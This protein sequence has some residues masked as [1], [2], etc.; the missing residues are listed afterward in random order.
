MADDP[1]RGL[2]M[3]TATGTSARSGQSSARQPVSWHAIDLDGVIARL[4][5]DPVRGL[6]AA[7]A[8]RRLTD[9]GPNALDEPPSRPWWRT[10]LRQ[11]EELVIWILLVAAVI[12]GGMGD[13][14]DAAAIVAI[15]LVNAIIGFLQEERAQKA[16][17]ALQRMAA[18][19]A[20][21]VRDGTRASIPAREVVTGDRIDLEAGDQVPADARLI[22]AFGLSAQESALTGESMP[23]EKSPAETLPAATPLGDRLSLVHAGTVVAAGSGS[24]IVVATGMS[25][26]IG[27]IAGMLE[28]SPPEPTPL[29][30]KLAALG[31]ILVAVCLAVVGMIFLMELARGGGLVELWRT[32]RLGDVLLRAVSLAVAAVPEG[33]PAVVTL[34]LAL[35]LQR[36]VA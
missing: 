22:E 16:L 28:R 17:A 29:Q 4:G 8:A 5:A 7:E 11:F 2:T 24:A 12:A 21:V 10:F 3:N 30:R 9:H 26:E 31:R 19:T 15:V 34:V 36:M 1:P 33:L 6:A 32:G 25:T 20:R 23:V 14:A 13:W 18:P 27:Q 35:G